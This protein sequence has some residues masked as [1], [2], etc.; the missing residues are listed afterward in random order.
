MGLL[1]RQVFCKMTA[2]KANAF[3]SV[4]TD[5]FDDSV[6]GLILR[7]TRSG[8][9]E[10]L[11]T[12]KLTDGDIQHICKLFDFENNGQHGLNAARRSAESIYFKFITN[13]YVEPFNNIDTS[14]APTRLYVTTPML[15]SMCDGQL[16]LDSRD[17]GYCIYK[18]MGSYHH[19]WHTHYFGK[20][21]FVTLNPPID[22]KG[23]FSRKLLKSQVDNINKKHDSEIF[24]LRD[25]SIALDK[26]RIIPD[27]N[28][29][30][31][32]LIDTIERNQLWMKAMR[33]AAPED[34]K[35]K[36]QAIIDYN[37][38]RMREYYGDM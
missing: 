11:Y 29:D 31:K 38:Q 22:N 30:S 25:E 5:Y 32:I 12:F 16:F 23:I 24:V 37:E 13:G 7:V 4:D 10:W 34:Q 27:G 18:K 9:K 1:S 20:V 2:S 15:E 21:C 14:V 6:P 3:K 26:K 19:F 28:M 17:R 33:D 8:K 35:H 36:L